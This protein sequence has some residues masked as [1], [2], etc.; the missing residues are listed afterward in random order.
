MCL[1]TSWLTPFLAIGGCV[2]EHH[3]ESVV[4]TLRLRL[5]VDLRD[6]IR[7]APDRWTVHGVEFLSLP[8][9]DHYPIPLEMLNLG[10][11]KILNALALSQRVLVHCQFGIGRSALMACCVLIA[12]GLD[13]VEA[14]RTAKRARPIVSP[15]PNQ[16]HAMLNF[17]QS[18][19]LEHGM[20]AGSATWHD[21]ASLAYATSRSADQA[22]CLS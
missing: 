19:R 1:D 12:Q 21:L 8:T 17:A 13:P 20:S 2:D 4:R 6:E 18:W 11:S 16:L 14:I 9:P 15:H 10:V 7:I 3:I 5:V 22:D